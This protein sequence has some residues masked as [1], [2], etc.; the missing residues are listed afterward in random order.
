MSSSCHSSAGSNIDEPEAVLDASRLIDNPEVPVVEGKELSVTQPATSQRKPRDRREFLWLAAAFAAG[1]G[2][3]YLLRGWSTWVPIGPAAEAKTD[4]KTTDAAA[5]AGTSVSQ[6]SLPDEYTLPAAYGDLGP[7][8]LK[9]GAID[10]D[11]FTQVY[12]EAGQSLTPE[13]LAILRAGSGAAVA[14][15]ADNAY[16]LLNF[17]WAAGLVNQNRILTEGTMMQYGGQEK[18]G[19]FAST[20]G[21]TIGGKPVTDLY[22]ST[23][24]FNLTGEQ[25]VRLEE[26]ANAVFRPCCNNPTS[27]PDCNHG[28]AM[29]GVLEL[30]ASQDVSVEEVFEAAKYLNAFWFPRQTY[31]LALAFNQG[32]GLDF[33][34]TDAR[35]LV[36]ANFSSSSGFQA[37]HQWLAENNL[38]EQVP[39]SGNSCGV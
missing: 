29:L 9:A 13:Q 6:V 31:E 3:G 22:A 33:A 32:K 19:S 8:L 24:L 26:V 15:N 38:L 4:T 25:Q 11:L 37:V 23:P 20:G 28:M 16:F 12:Q 21:W 17:F 30:L 36:S 1:L 18:I 39:N 14:I 35:E 7:R 34:E 5:E 27:F 2:G 10:Y